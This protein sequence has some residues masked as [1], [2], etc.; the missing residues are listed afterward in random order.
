MGADIQDKVI[1]NRIP[2][3]R[4]STRAQSS[5]DADASE[6][7]ISNAGVGG[8]L[9]M[10]RLIHLPMHVSGFTATKY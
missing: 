10:A 1:L 5:G 6:Y 4:V 3:A 8:T 2:S 9:D 7:R